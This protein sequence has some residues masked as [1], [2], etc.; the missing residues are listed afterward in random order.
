V[1]GALAAPAQGLDLEHVHPVGK[2]DQAPAPGE[3]PGAEVAED[4]EGEDVDLELV[5]DP[6]Q[7]V[8]LMGR[9]ELGLVADQVVDPAAL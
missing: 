4:A 6:G 2:L 3:Q 9:I 5:D 8:D 1:R 7:L